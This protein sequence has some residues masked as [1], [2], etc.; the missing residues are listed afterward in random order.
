VENTESFVFVGN[1][2]PISWPSIPQSVFLPVQKH[3]RP[4]LAHSQAMLI[5]G[6][7]LADNLTLNF[8]ETRIVSINAMKII[9]HYRADF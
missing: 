6:M 9:V 1:R 7:P 5:R 2:T 4:E 3:T 8:H